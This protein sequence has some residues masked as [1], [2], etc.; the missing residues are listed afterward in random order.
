MDCRK[1]EQLISPYVDGE[2][3]RAETDMVRA[4]LSACAD[5]QQEYEDFVLISSVMKSV[6]LSGT[7][8]T[9]FSTAVMKRIRRK[10]KSFT[11]Y[12]ENQLVGPQLEAN[13]CRHSSGS[14]A[15]DEHNAYEWHR[16]SGTDCR[17]PSL[18]LAA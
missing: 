5:C 18:H 17:Q 12:Q 6:S 4:H 15:D 13:S 14:S 2:L 11:A 8:P 1:I 9:G 3:T 16:T 10:R 7:C